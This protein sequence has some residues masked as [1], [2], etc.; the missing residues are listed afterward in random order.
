VVHDLAFL[1]DGRAL[2]SASGDGTV[3]LW[4]LD[5]HE[6][7]VFEGHAAPVFGLAVSP[8]GRTIAS[9]SGDANVRLWAVVGLPRSHEELLGFLYGLSHEHYAHGIPEEP[10]EQ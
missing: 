3:S 5:T 7:R 10:D 6:R 4:D 8:D 9:A 2:A 1:P